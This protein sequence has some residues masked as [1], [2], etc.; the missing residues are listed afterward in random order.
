MNSLKKKSILLLEKNFSKSNLK[1]IYYIIIALGVLHIRTG[2]SLLKEVFSTIQVVIFLVFALVICIVL[3]LI[4]SRLIRSIIVVIQDV[5]TLAK[6]KIDLYVSTLDAENRRRVFFVGSWIILIF[7][8]FLVCCFFWKETLHEAFLG[9]TNVVFLSKI[10]YNAIYVFLEL[11]YLSFATT[12]KIVYN[13]IM[14]DLFELYYDI[15]FDIVELYYDLFYFV[16]ETL[17]KSMHFMILVCLICYEIFLFIVYFIFTYLPAIGQV[18]YNLFLDWVIVTYR[19]VL[20]DYNLFLDWIVVT[21]PYVSELFY[22][23]IFF[24]I[25]VV[26]SATCVGLC[27]AKAELQRESLMAKQFVLEIDI[28][29]GDI[30]KFRSSYLGLIDNVIEISI[31][32]VVF[33]LMEGI[34]RYVKEKL[35]SYYMRA[36]MA[37]YFKDQA[38]KSG[39]LDFLNSKPD[40]LSKL[41]LVKSNPD[42]LIKLDL[43]KS[44]PDELSKLDLAKS[45]PN[46]S[47]KR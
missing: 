15:M 45:N 40:E 43:V 18:G 13:N 11:S 2:Y 22:K 23:S 36:K 34:Y 33:F 38:D 9:Y 29:I 27:E 44:N 31:W 6:I 12:A 10:L 46:S 8:T 30:I 32:R 21:Y 3:V 19:Y 1:R 14:F 25:Y 47:G 20:V 24:D 42:E 35:S 37:A 16:M 39:K 26:V 28:G 17:E 4:L 5:S 41:D 7:P